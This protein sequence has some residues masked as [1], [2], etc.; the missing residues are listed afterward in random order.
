MHHASLKLNRRYEIFSINT[1]HFV[2]ILTSCQHHLYWFVYGSL[3]M[4]PPLLTGISRVK[5]SIEKF[6]MEKTKS[7][8]E[9][10]IYWNGFL[11]ERKEK[12]NSII[13]ST[14]FIQV[15]KKF[16]LIDRYLLSPSYW[17]SLSRFMSLLICKSVSNELPKKW[18]V[19]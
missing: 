10:A 9:E 13:H 5:F 16:A 11:G 14:V 8:S 15:D 12:T 1:F 4:I 7:L 6:E 17:P 18:M 3:N 19:F 2:H